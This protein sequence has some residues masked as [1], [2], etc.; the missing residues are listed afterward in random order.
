[1]E[2][3]ALRALQA[4]CSE[5][6]DRVDADMHIQTNLQLMLTAQ[7]ASKAECAFWVVK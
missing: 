3:A 7:Y 5:D 4:E 6:D 2:E 1:M